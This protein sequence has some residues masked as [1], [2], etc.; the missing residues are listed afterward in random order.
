MDAVD[1]VRIIQEYVN[2]KHFFATSKKLAQ[3]KHCCY[4]WI[5]TR[6]ASL[7]FYY[8]TTFRETLYNLLLEPRKQI[9]LNLSEC[10]NITDVSALGNV[11]I[12]K[13]GK[14]DTI[15]TSQIQPMYIA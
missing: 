11:H 2:L 10:S 6:K 5:L 9:A 14:C 13:F 3:V 15:T 7:N 4:Y 12:L 8:N 1:I